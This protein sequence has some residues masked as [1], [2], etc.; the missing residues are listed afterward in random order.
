MRQQKGEQDDHI[1]QSFRSAIDM[2]SCKESGL[3]KESLH[4]LGI[5][6]NST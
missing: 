6:R 1:M 5:I 4:L 3:H 2:H